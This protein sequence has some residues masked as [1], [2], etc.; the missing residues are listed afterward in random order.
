[1]QN[2]V[3]NSPAGKKALALHSETVAAVLVE[4]TLMKRERKVLL[5]LKS[6]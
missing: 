4:S 2:V 3:K 1:M 5:S 6:N